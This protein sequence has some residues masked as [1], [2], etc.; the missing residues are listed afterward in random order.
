VGFGV[1]ETRGVAMAVGNAVTSEDI[2]GVT[3][4]TGVGAKPVPVGAKVGATVLAPSA[5]LVPDLV[6]RFGT[7]VALGAK[8]GDTSLPMSAAVLAPRFG[9]MAPICPKTK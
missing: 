8:V 1:T 5:K 4:T 7:S 2:R 3:D 6:P 9:K